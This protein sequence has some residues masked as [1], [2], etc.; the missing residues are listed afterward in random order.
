MNIDVIRSVLLWC[1]IINM[2]IFLYWFA[3]FA[4][5]HDLLYRI[6]SK[7]F[8]IPVEKFD[9]THYA[10]M[11]IFKIVIIVFNLVPYIALCIVG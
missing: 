10:M 6:H 7:W 1:L 9:A 4:L 11:G 8:K 2:G 5:A 3:F